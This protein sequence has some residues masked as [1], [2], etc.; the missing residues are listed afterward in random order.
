[1]SPVVHQI[2][3]LLLPAITANLPTWDGWLNHVFPSPGPDLG[4]KLASI[5]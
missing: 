3:P 4:T 2:V 1:M 5:N